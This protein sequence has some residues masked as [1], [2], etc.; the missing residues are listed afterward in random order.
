MSRFGKKPQQPS[1]VEIFDYVR[2]AKVDHPDWLMRYYSMRPEKF[3][4]P[5]AD[6]LARDCKMEPL[7]YEDLVRKFAE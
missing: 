2:N 6:N 4:D 1:R 5:V 3:P 7:K